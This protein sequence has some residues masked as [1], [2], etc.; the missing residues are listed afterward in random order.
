[1]VVGWVSQKQKCLCYTHPLVYHER[2][3]G[4]LPDASAVSLW[5][6]HQNHEPFGSILL[7]FTQSGY[8]AVRP[9]FVL[10]CF[11]LQRLFKPIFVAACL[12]ELWRDGGSAQLT[13]PPEISSQ[14]TYIGTPV[15][16]SPCLCPVP[17]MTYLATFLSFRPLFY[18]L[19]SFVVA[20]HL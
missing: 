12:A 15:L 11:V 5:T 4:Y 14:Y 16:I 7:I 8:Y 6:S 20:I 1:M 13:H 18:Y 2:L 17:Q 19:L 9:F 10:F 3:S